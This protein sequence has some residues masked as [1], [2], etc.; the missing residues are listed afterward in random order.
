MTLTD[1]S[2]E[3]GRFCLEESPVLIIDDA[4]EIDPVTAGAIASAHNADTFQVVTSSKKTYSWSSG[5][6]VLG[7][8]PAAQLKMP[9]LTYNSL[10]HLAEKILGSP[11]DPISISRVAV[12]SGKLFSVASSVLLIGKQSK[13]ITQNRFGLW[14]A[15]DELW[16]PELTA[17]AESYLVGISPELYDAA[18]VL[19]S[20]GPLSAPNATEKIGPLRLRALLEAGFIRS[21]TANGKTTVGVF[22]PLMSE[23]FSRNSTFLNVDSK[24][25][26]CLAYSTEIAIINYQQANEINKLLD[27][28]RNAWLKAPTSANA[29]ELGHVLIK[30][31]RPQ[32]E[33]TNMIANTEIGNESYDD[34]AFFIWC[35]LWKMGNTHTLDKALAEIDQKREKMPQFDAFL[36]AGQAYLSYNNY[37]KATPEMLAPAG[38]NEHRSGEVVLQAARIQQAI[39][40]GAT[41]TARRLLD[42]FAPTDPSLKDYVQYWDGICEI[43]TGDLKSGIKKSLSPTDTMHRDSLFTSSSITSY[44]A[45]LGLLLAGNLKE[46]HDLIENVAT[47]VPIIFSQFSTSNNFLR[48]AELIYGWKE[49]Q[50]GSKKFPMDMIQMELLVLHIMSLFK[51]QKLPKNIDKRVWD[52]VEVLLQEDYNVSSLLFTMEATFFSSPS[53]NVLKAVEAKLE[54]LE[55]PLLQ[56]IASF[57][58]AH[59]KKDLRKLEEVAHLFVKNRWF[60]LAVRAY[61]LRALLL[62]SEGNYAESVADANTAWDIAEGCRNP[63]LFFP[64]VSE[65][66]LSN[67]ETEVMQLLM[68]GHSNKDIASPLSMSIRTVDTH[69]HNISGKIGVTGRNALIRVGNTWL[70]PN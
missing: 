41:D 53:K 67:R 30:A 13:R 43:I 32:L 6:L 63:S 65:I 24:N 64:L 44:A 7:I 5:S 56:G 61:I 58:L 3:L 60:Y 37:R 11:L 49:Y 48:L 69:L 14:S 31:N 19:A 51:E 25:S 15:A 46:A 45:A 26:G 36:R 22:P 38:M 39:K 16:T 62:R 34:A 17:L 40:A 52:I 20:S 8:A 1:A 33:I 50:T 42:S 12:F 55:S 23:Y 29:M 9:D 47:H 18:C 59:A 4:D 54:T 27:E 35:C 66:G 57:I 68:K 70:Q 10:N 21:A 2:A 28:K